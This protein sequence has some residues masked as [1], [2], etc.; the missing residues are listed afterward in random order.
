MQSLRIV[1]TKEKF[2]IVFCYF[3]AIKNIFQ[4]SSSANFPMKWTCWGMHVFFGFNKSIL[5]RL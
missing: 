1:K 5:M 2:R 4:L 3:A